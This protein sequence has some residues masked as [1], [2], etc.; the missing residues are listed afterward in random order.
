MLLGFGDAELVVGVADVGGQVVPAVGLLL[1]RAHEVLD[2]VEVDA[3]QVGAPQRHRLLLE[4]AQALEPLLEHP[5]GLVL[6]RRDVAHDLLVQATPRR[7][8]GHVGVGPAELVPAE[9]VEL[10]DARLSSCDD[11]SGRRRAVNCSVDCCTGTCCQRDVGRAYAVAVGDGGQPLHVRAQQ[12]AEH[13]GLG[14]AQLREV[15]GDV[16]DRAVV[17]ADLHA[18]A[19]LVRRGG[20]SVGSQ[21]PQPIQPDADQRARRPARRR[22][23]LRGQRS[24]CRAK[25][26]TAPSPPVVRR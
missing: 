18:R 2:V 10:W 8:P 3:R 26:V 17:L 13:L 14:L 21:A 20:V 23:E 22:S 25:A 16:R 6:L 12:P 9:L 24:R 5:G 4:D 7:C 1:G 15:G 11:L 19:G